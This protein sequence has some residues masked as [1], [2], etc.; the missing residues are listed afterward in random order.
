MPKYPEVIVKKSEFV[1]NNAQSVVGIMIFHLRRYM[2]DNKW[3]YKKLDVE[4]S[5]FVRGTKD[6]GFEEVIEYA[7]IWT[8]WW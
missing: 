6:L 8:T 7:K 1:E 3:T 2:R 4:I 5:N